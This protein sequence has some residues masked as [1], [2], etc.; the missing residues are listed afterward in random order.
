MGKLL[1]DLS[2]PALILCKHKTEVRVN[3]N[4]NKHFLLV[5]IYLCRA[6][7]TAARLKKKRRKKDVINKAVIHGKDLIK[8]TGNVYM[9]VYYYK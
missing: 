8:D 4:C 6:G 5:K 9:L 1:I 3:E 2:A 7:K